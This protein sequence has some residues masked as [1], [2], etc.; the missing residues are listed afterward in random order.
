M[1]LVRCKHINGIHL[2][3][4]VTRNREFKPARFVCSLSKIP[5]IDTAV[6]RSQG[7]VSVSLDPDDGIAG[8]FF[9]S[10]RHNQVEISFGTCV[11]GFPD[12]RNSGKNN[13]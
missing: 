2:A 10:I 3:T 4:G 5:N 8:I 11:E 13:F 7:T 9:T 12:G 6:R 1:V